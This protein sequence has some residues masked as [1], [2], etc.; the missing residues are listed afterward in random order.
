MTEQLQKKVDRAV[1]LLQSAVPREVWRE[2]IQ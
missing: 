2:P 1:K